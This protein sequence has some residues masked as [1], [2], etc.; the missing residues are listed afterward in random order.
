MGITLIDT[1][2]HIYDKKF[3]SDIQDIIHRAIDSGV[4]KIFLPNIDHTTIDSMLEL[5]NMFPDVCVPMMGLHPCHVKEDFE[6][7]LYIVEDWFSKRAFA[8]VGECGLDYY[9]DLTFKEQQ[10]EA[11]KIQSALAIKHNTPIILHTRNANADSI[12]LIQSFK[13]QSEK[14]K[15]I[16]HC[17]SGSIKEGQAI[18]NMG[19]K[20]G[21]GGVLTFKNGGLKEIVNAF[22]LQ[23]LV[24]ETDSPYLAPVPFRGKRNE[25]SYVRYVAEE[26]SKCLGLS[27]EEVAK[28]TSQNAMDLFEN[29]FN[30]SRV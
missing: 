30:L 16:F 29:Y 17:F 27:L 21:L 6:K 1:H 13:E 5:E 26:L 24:L 8:G 23:S 15:G 19:F 28:A 2:A 22:K 14:F 9:W 20:I 4:Q 10:A 25:P 11:L 12:A 7:E 18:E 3:K